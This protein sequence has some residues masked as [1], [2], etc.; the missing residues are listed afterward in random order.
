MFETMEHFLHRPRSFMDQYFIFALPPHIK[1]HLI[2][3]YYSFDESVV[4]E[5]LGKRLT[6]R[7]RK[8]LDD[9]AEKTK[10]PLH[11]C[12]RQFDNLKRIYKKVEDLQGDLITN[13]QTKFLLNLDVASSYSYILFM[14]ENRIDTTKKK[15]SFMYFRD[16]EYCASVFMKY[17][18]DSLHHEDIDENLAQDLRDLK[19]TLSVDKN[20]PDQFVQLLPTTSALDRER[21]YLLHKIMFRNILQIG[22]TLSQKE[23]RDIFIALME[24][25]V[26]PIF[27]AGDI[28]VDQF[29]F[30]FQH[31]SCSFTS[32]ESFKPAFRER[33]HKSWSRLI[34][35]IK[36]SCVRM[37]R[38]YQDSR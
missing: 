34:D 10:V 3:K 12:R 38:S 2:E 25:I 19:T 17:W 14:T 21:V 29:E 7:S 5:L 24:K 23:F 26:E 32:V 20:L 18:T 16:F 37:M 4:R 15:L 35:G 33:Y 9:V 13:I 11:S 31:L 27:N 30:F 36:L 8:D 1:K 6:S 28:T 22:S